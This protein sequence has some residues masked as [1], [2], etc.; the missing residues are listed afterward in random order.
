M[1]LKN[2]FDDRLNNEAQVPK[3][4]L[5]ELINQ[6]QALRNNS[7]VT[8]N[9][10]QTIRNNSQLIRDELHKLRNKAYLI[11]NNSQVIRNNC[12]ALRNKEHISKNKAQIPKNKLHELINQSQ[13]LRNNSQVTRNEA[14]SVRNNSQVIR[15]DL[16]KLSNES[17]VIK[18][19]SQALR[20]KEQI[21]KNKAQVPKNELHKLINQSQALRN[22]FQITRNEAQTIRNNSQV[23]SDELHELRNEAH[24]IKNNSQALR[25]KASVHRDNDKDNTALDKINN[26]IGLINKKDK[27][28]FEVNTIVTNKVKHI[29]EAMHELQDEIYDDPWLRLIELNMINDILHDALNVV[30]KEIYGK[31]RKSSIIINIDKDKDIDGYVSKLTD[32]I[33]NKIELIN[34]IG[35]TIDQVLQERNN[36]TNITNE[37]I[38]KA[39]EM[40][41]DTLY[42]IDDNLDKIITQTRKKIKIS[43]IPEAVTLPETKTKYIDKSKTKYKDKDKTKTIIDKIDNKKNLINKI[44]IRLSKAK[45]KVINNIKSV[46]KA[47]CKLQ[48][49]IYLNDTWLRLDELNR[50]D[51]MF[52]DTLNVVWYEIYEK[53]KKSSKMITK[54]N[55]KTLANM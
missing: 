33:N 3:N 1:L 20:N 14:Q 8:R 13:P 7:Q 18:N 22:N 41:N 47:K 9:E 26:K 34:K 6:S 54:V 43:T 48:D 31:N 45:T 17:H 55:I 40:D 32:V 44:N 46:Y 36:E 29:Y 28:L 15:D 37:K 27:I 19:N 25:N 39:S 49:E 16:N 38:L 30:S 42:L 52:N 35:E 24:V 50:I 10:V 51:T 23:I 4:E 12:Q 5:H 2:K 11:K 53:N 21:P